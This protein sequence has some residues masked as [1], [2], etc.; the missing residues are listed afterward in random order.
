MHSLRVWCSDRSDL[1]ST[2]DYARLRELV[3]SRDRVFLLHIDCESRKNVSGNMLVYSNML[4]RSH[5]LMCAC[6]CA[7]VEV[8]LRNA[9][10]T[11]L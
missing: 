5:P 1:A 8:G 10:L 7:G 9:Y 6:D 2:A 4:S 11:V 3:N